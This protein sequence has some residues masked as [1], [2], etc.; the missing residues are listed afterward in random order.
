M[1][2]GKQKLEVAIILDNIRSVFNVGSI[3]RTAETLGIKKIYCIGTTPTPVD[4]FGRR[5][6]DFSKVSLGAEEIVGW[7]H[8]RNVGEESLNS[9]KIEIDTVMLINKLNKDGYKIIAL[10]QSLRSVDY[11]KDLLQGIFS[12]SVGEETYSKGRVAIILG[13]EVSGVSSKLLK[14]A[15]IIAEIPML[16]KKESLNVAVAG[17]VFLFRIL[18]R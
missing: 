6:K 14:S 12:N 4:R 7:E 2:L 8:I 15:D 13:N 9:G 3:F 10:E 5:R 18:D 17:A 1:P 16:G 11:K